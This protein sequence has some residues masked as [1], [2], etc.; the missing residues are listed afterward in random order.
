MIKDVNGN[1]KWKNITLILLIILSVGVVAYF[2][3]NTIKESELEY[4]SLAGDKEE[5]T[6]KEVQEEIKKE[7]KVDFSKYSNEELTNLAVEGTKL[8]KELGGVRK[9]SKEEDGD[10]YIF[11]IAGKYN[12]VEKRKEAINKY[13]AKGIYEEKY[14]KKGEE[15]YV[16]VPDYKNFY[17]SYEFQDIISREVK[18]NILYVK[19]KAATTQGYPMGSRTTKTVQYKEEDGVLKL[20]SKPFE[21]SFLNFWEN[22]NDDKNEE[23]ELMEE[24][25]IKEIKSKLSKVLREDQRVNGIFQVYMDNKNGHVYYGI[26]ISEPTQNAI[27]YYYNK[28]T[29]AIYGHYEKRFVA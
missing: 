11:P 1:I 3:I 16:G 12:T 15:T 13:Y 20:N 17:Q 6:N 26:T 19:Y 23:Y 7:I 10:Y 27:S 8:N 5:E 25:L 21:E 9:F 29:G 22:I 28:N 18:E 14:I 4:E 2:G 24:N